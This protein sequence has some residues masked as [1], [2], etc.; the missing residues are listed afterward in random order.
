MEMEE[1]KW[2]TLITV[3]KKNKKTDNLRAKAK[4]HCQRERH[5]HDF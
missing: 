3:K 1:K 5:R 2:F 4:T